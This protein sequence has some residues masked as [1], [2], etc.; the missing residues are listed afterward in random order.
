M[1]CFHPH[2]P[3]LHLTQSNRS[4]LEPYRVDREPSHATPRVPD[5]APF[6]PTP[7][8]PT[9]ETPTPT[10]RQPVP[11]AADGWIQTADRNSSFIDLPPHPL[12][13]PVVTMLATSPPST[14]RLFDVSV[15]DAL[16][17]Q[18]PTVSSRDYAYA[19]AT[20]PTDLSHPPTAASQGSTGFSQFD[21]ISPPHHHSQAAAVQSGRTARESSRT[22]TL[23]REPS[24]T[25]R[26]AEEWREVNPAIISPQS[27]P[28]HVYHGDVR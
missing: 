13:D 12:S 19:P 5:V 9:L 18:Y 4:R 3:P 7:L 11:L 26:I 24:Q 27:N 28:T 17:P 23:Q 10:L 8:V 15:A 14:T 25:E 2:I 21:L 16:A 1:T 20:Q 22:H 6:A